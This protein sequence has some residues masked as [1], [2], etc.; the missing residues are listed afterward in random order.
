MAKFFTGFGAF[1]LIVAAVV[2]S[3]TF[4]IVDESEQALLIQLGDPKKKE[5]TAGL[6]MKIPFIQNVIKVSRKNLEYDVERPIE[7]IAENEER[8]V[9]DAFVRYEIIDPLVYYKTFPGSTS[10]QQL[11]D[12]GDNNISSILEGSIREALGALTITEIINT[13]RAELMQTITTTTAAEATKFGVRIIDV[14]IRRAD[15]PEENAEKVF[16]RMRSERQQ[17]AQRIRSEGQE[18]AVKIKAEA[19][20]DRATL[21]AEA[22]EQSQKVRGEADAER[23]AIFAAAYSRDAE[24]FAFYRS[25]TAYEEALRND[26]NGDTSM[27]MSPDSEFFRYFN[28]VRGKK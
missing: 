8:L 12:R 14:K 9:I 19:D 13:K 21:V 18:A 27:L 23:N 20:K 25:M 26:A 4:Y 17:Q 15:F 3:Q 16:E 1:I 28:D 10:W 6:K 7:V 22:Q 2:I 24:F 11:K 5:D